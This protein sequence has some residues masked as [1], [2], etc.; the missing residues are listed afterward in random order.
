MRIEL[1]LA[2]RPTENRR[3]F[4][5][6]TGTGIVV[7]LALAVL[8]GAWYW[9]RWAGERDVARRTTQAQAETKRLDEEQKTLADSFERQEAVRIFDTSYFLNTLILQKG[10]SWTQLFMDLEKLV[11]S[12]VQVVAIHPQVLDSNSINLDLQVAGKNIEQLLEFVRQLERSDKFWRTELKQETPPAGGM[13]SSTRLTLSVI[14]A[15]K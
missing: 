10:F 5:A 1:N 9:H 11:P 8:Q 7:L 13:D 3:R 6:L 12:D 14:Y 2:T 4:L 15:Q